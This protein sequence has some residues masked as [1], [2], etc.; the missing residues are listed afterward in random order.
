M[1][2]FPVS[3]ATTP[4]ELEADV[5]VPVDVAGLDLVRVPARP[6]QPSQ[7][8]DRRQRPE[9]ADGQ[10]E[11]HLKASLLPEYVEGPVRPY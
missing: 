6:D 7:V 11:T 2:C 5:G 4:E 10:R 9:A 8:L 1:C 3:A